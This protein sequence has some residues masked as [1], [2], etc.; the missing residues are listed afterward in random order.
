[1][2]AIVLSTPVEI[3]IELSGGSA[4]GSVGGLD[5]TAVTLERGF[6]VFRDYSLSGVSRG[7]ALL[8]VVLVQTSTVTLE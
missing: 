8:R 7:I 6:V 5:R 2:S 4:W 3:T 1:M